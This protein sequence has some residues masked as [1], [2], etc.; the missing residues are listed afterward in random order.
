MQIAQLILIA[1][2]AY[3]AIGVIFALAFVTRGLGQ[4]DHAA[5]TAPWMVRLLLF[6]GSVALWPILARKWAKRHGAEGHK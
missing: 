5:Q 1:I 6:P 2:G 4:V 3:A